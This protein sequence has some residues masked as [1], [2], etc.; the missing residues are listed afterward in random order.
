VPAAS[1]A[2]VPFDRSGTLTFL[3]TDIVGST[4]LWEQQ[5]EAMRAALAHHDQILRQAIGATGGQVFKTVGDSFY[6][7]FSSPS[8][9]LQASLDAQ[10]ALGS[11]AWATFGLASPL[12]VRMALH[13]GAAEWRDG[14]YFGPPLNRVARLL[15][16]GHGGQVCPSVDGFHAEI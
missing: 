11:A 3:F 1:S 7:V 10:R 13:A 2:P 8:Q 9:A 4:Q 6:A 14:D 16:A 12:Q 15:A 5:P